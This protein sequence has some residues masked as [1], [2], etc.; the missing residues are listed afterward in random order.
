MYWLDFGVDGFRVDAIPFIY[1]DA[2]LRNEPLSNKTGKLLC[3]MIVRCSDRIKALWILELS[4]EGWEYPFHLNDT[5]TGSVFKG[6][7]MANVSSNM[8]ASTL[9]NLKFRS[10]WKPLK[11]LLRKIGKHNKSFFLI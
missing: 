1:E 3:D 7:L 2:K 8:N 5:V 9:Y 10:E 4:L 11:L 6:V